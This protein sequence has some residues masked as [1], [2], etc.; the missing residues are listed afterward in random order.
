M[1]KLFCLHCNALQR[2]RSDSRDSNQTTTQP[3]RQ[4]S[5]QE[6]SN[7]DLCGVSE[8]GQLLVFWLSEDTLLH[9]QMPGGY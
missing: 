6:Q 5:E 9:R 2:Q 1:I 3:Q 4:K 7:E 8:S